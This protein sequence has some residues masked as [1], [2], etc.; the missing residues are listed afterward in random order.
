MAVVG[1]ISAIIQGVFT[2]L[3]YSKNKRALIPMKLFIKKAALSGILAMSALFAASQADAAVFTAGDLL[4]GFRATGGQG[5]DQTIVINLGAGTTYRDST[6]N[7]INIV[8]IGANLE[9][10]YGD[11]WYDRTDLY[12]GVIGVRTNA[13]SGAAVNG[14]PYRTIYASSSRNSDGSVAGLANSPSWVIGSSTD[15]GTGSTQIVGFQ[16]NYSTSTASSNPQVSVISTSLD[17][18]WENYNNGSTSFAIFN[19]GIEQSFGAGAWGTL[20]AAGSV[21]GALDLQRILATTSGANPTGTL[22]TGSYEGTFTIDQDGNVSFITVPEPSTY[23]LIALGLVAIVVF[24]RR[25][26]LNA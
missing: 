15:M 5:S 18:T 10:I 1:L 14:D 23:A 22:R 9:S 21:E 16:S 24:R 7:V 4:M 6:G 11:T 3:G 26:S 13:S 19:G 20:G 25:L 17:N 8:N 2:S 12:F